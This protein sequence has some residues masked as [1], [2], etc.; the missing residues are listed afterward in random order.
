MFNNSD[1]DSILQAIVQEEP[2]YRELFE[3]RESMDNTLYILL[4]NISAAFL[5]ISTTPTL[6]FNSTFILLTYLPKLINEVRVTGNLVESH[7]IYIKKLLG[8]IL[9]QV[10]IYFGDKEKPISAFI[11]VIDQIHTAIDGKEVDDSSTK[12]LGEENEEN[13]KADLE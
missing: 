13:S 5:K 3:L 7:S 6:K 8:E 12:E 2:L 10:E 11:A 1:H 9:I 4:V